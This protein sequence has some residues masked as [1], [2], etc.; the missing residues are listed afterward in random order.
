MH[1]EY[2]NQ[3]INRLDAM[4]SLYD[5]CDIHILASAKDWEHEIGPGDFSLDC[6]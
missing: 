6:R 4:I 5:R 1:S 2:G 3:S